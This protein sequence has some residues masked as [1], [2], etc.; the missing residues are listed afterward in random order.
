MPA[1][2]RVVVD[3]GAGQV[4][5][6]GVTG[7]LDLHT[8]AGEVI[9]TGATGGGRLDTGAGMV[10]F[11]GEP[12]GN[13]YLQTGVG[14]IVIALPSGANVDIDLTT[15]LGDVDVDAF[16]VVGRVSPRDVQGIIGSGGPSIKAHTGT[17]SI[18]VVVLR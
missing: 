9:A 6:G 13:L 7:E 10:R 3:S 11:E 5:V 15:A 16:D 18:R 12:A 2:A 8:G 4:I 1:D 14:E 17:G